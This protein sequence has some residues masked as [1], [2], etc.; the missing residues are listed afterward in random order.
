MSVDKTESGW[1]ARWRDQSGK[2]RARTFRLKAD[3]V[4]FEAKMRL[5]ARTRGFVAPS[6]GKM[7]INELTE[8]WLT[9]SIHLAPRSLLTYRRDLTRYV[10][11]ALGT[12]SLDRLAPEMIQT[13]LA[14][15]LKRYSPSSVHRFYR[16]LHTML[17]WAVLQDMLLVNPCK[18]VNAP[19]VPRKEAKYLS[20]AEVERVA[21]EMPDRYR[22]FILVAAY[23]GL[24]WGELTGLRRG[25]V[26]GARITITE[27]LVIEDGEFVRR[28]PKTPS[29]RRTVLLPASIGEELAHHM[30][31]FSPPGA[32]S[33]V[34]VNQNNDPVG[35]SFRDNI[36]ARACFRAG[37]ARQELNSRT[38]KLQIRGAPTIHQLRHTAVALAIAAGAHPKAIQARLGHS[39]IMVTMNTYGHLLDAVGEEVAEALND[40]RPSK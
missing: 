22:A 28:P 32:D 2:Q 14:D 24:R 23:G 12:V 3:A 1:R 34:F 26:D 15:E 5:E 11:P 31:Q 6:S 13:F 4:S 17:E 40:L 39:S 8:L 25:S 37:L 30:E 33:L 36:W 35:P 16:T 21:D 9:A 18:R 38:G 7:T 29:S 27:Q 10:L 20:A 19:K